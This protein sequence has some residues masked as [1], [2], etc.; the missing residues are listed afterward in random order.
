MPVCSTRLKNSKECRTICCKSFLDDFRPVSIKMA[1]EQNLSL[2][3]TKISGLCGR[4]MCCLQYE[5]ACYEQMRKLMPRTGR[6]IETPDGVG[7]AIDN[8]IVTEK[9]RVKLTAADGTIDIREYP[10]T[11]LG[12][13]AAERAKERLKVQQEEN[14]AAQSDREAP[15]ESEETAAVQAYAARNR[16]DQGQRRESR[17]PRSDA[18]QENPPAPSTE[19]S[20]A[21]EQ[22]S[23][24]RSRPQ[25]TPRPPKAPQQP[26]KNNGE[27]NPDKG[28]KP[29]P[30]KEQQPRAP[31]NQPKAPQNQSKAPQNQAKA[32]QSQPNSETGTADPA[33]KRRKPYYRRRPSNK[34]PGTPAEK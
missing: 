21:Q 25:R 1:K 6:E 31:Q 34:N 15:A 7:L 10:Y 33:A 8:N 11:D 32:P 13:G 5:E 4:L 30:P 19:E 26:R 23:S 22:P 2:S 12:P 17:P 14:A 3:P 20:V 29:N 18:K 9:T 16:R 28:Q 24:N 27:L